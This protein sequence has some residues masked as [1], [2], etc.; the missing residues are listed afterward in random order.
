MIA[1]LVA[2]LPRATGG[3]P[4]K[5]LADSPDVCV[6]GELGALQRKHQDTAHSFRP[7]AF[8][9]RQLGLDLETE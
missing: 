1:Y 8:E 9:T 3:S 4:P 6:D 2:L 5:P 7:H